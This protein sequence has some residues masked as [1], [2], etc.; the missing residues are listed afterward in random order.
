MCSGENVYGIIAG[1]I[2][3]AAVLVMAYADKH[4]GDAHV[5][6]PAHAV[7]KTVEITPPVSIRLSQAGV[8]LD[9]NLR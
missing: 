3:A 2:T 5:A 6:R 9:I 8:R 1:L 4:G 7:V